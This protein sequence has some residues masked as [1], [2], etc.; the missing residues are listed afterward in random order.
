MSWLINHALDAIVDRQLEL[1]E[2]ALSR[3]AVIFSDA[4]DRL[5]DVAEWCRFLT[6]VTRT[7]P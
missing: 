4:A 5:D 2:W 6:S 3:G 1:A 7:A